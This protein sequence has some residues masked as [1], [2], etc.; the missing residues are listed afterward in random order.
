[1]AQRDV[2]PFTPVKVTAEAAQC[3]MRAVTHG[4]ELAM[5]ATVTA[6]WLRELFGKLP[7]LRHARTRPILLQLLCP[8]LSGASLTT[9]TDGE[10]AERSRTRDDQSPWLFLQQPMGVDYEAL[11]D[12]ESYVNQKMKTGACES[13][14]HL[15]SRAS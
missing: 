15:H 11:R 2:G 1:M 5:V 8:R 13:G 6:T 7:S 12:F 9:L 14:G 4:K 3:Q 10:K